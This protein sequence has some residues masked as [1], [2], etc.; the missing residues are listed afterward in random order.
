MIALVPLRTI[1]ASRTEHLLD[2]AFGRER[3]RRTAYRLREAMAAID[4]LS[5]AAVAEAKTEAKT[6]AKMD[7]RLLGCVQCWP[8]AHRTRH[9]VIPLVMVGPVA[10][11]PDYQKA[12]IGQSM[13]TRVLAVAQTK[14]DGALMMIGDSEYYGRFFD[15][16]A[17]W[18]ANWEI[19]GPV[20]RYRLLARPIGVFS[21]PEH[22]GQIGPRRLARED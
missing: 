11:Q 16:S 21:P 10:V 3:L 14:A 8:V 17:H 20:E 22:S 2:A 1:A 9:E 19:D 15:F 6:E 5:F 7:E 12:Q 18:T 13:M 4:A